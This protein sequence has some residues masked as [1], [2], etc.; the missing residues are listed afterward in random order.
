M[1]FTYA[2]YNKIKDKIYIGHTK[3][4]EQRI[5][6]HNQLL[7]N[8]LTSYTSKNR[9]LWKLVYQEEFETRGEAM[10]REKELKTSRGRYFIKK[11]IDNT[12]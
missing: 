4:L 5:E 8:K 12:K 11:N 2:I 1:F 9:G 3:D 10:K 6:R 7:P